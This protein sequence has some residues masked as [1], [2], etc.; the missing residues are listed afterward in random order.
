MVVP[1]RAVPC[2]AVPCRAVLA[3]DAVAEGRDVLQ[4]V[5]LVELV[6]GH[7][8]AAEDPLPGEGQ[9][10]GGPQEVLHLLAPADRGRPAPGRPAACGG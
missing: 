4:P 8:P 9:L 10:S 2:R 3:Q 1:C 7:V 5:S 6:G